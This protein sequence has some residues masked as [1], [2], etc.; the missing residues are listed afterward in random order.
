MPYT[1]TCRTADGVERTVEVTEGPNVCPIW[2]YHKDG[3][4]LIG[5]GEAKHR[6]Q[7]GGENFYVA[8]ADATPVA[9]PERETGKI[10]VFDPES[11]TWSQV[12]DRSLSNYWSTEEATLARPVR[13]MDPVADVS[14]GLTTVAPCSYDPGNEHLCW[15]ADTCTWCAEPNV[16]LTAAEK[17]AKV[18]LSTSEL[19]ELLGL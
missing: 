2:A 4:Y 7:Y 19:R 6:P 11:Q 17:L 12:E 16:Q 1:V 9:P 13:I 8:P 10:P 14:V 18:G 15:N 5:K 3:R